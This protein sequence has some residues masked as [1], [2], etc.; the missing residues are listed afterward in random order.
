M[1]QTGF[2][3]CRSIH[4]SRRRRRGPPWMHGGGPRRLPDWVLPRPRSAVTRHRRRFVAAQAAHLTEAMTRCADAAG[5][6]QPRVLFSAHGLPQKIVAAGDPYQ[7][8]VE[9]TAAAVAAAA[10]LRND[11]WLVCYQSRVGPLKWIGPET[12]EEISRAGAECTP[13][14]VVPIAFVSE[15][16]ETLVELDIEYRHLA[17]TAGVPAYERAPTVRSHPRFIE[18]LAELVG[19][20]S[21]SG[22]STRS[23][24]GHRQCPGT[25]SACAMAHS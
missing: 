13:V 11:S 9:Q 12:K 19:S 5:G 16:S 10:D 2:A 18:G 20:C 4:S 25:I 7:W 3:S 24:L 8:Q 1:D 21:W 15:H 6:M 23:S 22:V 14:V 17:E